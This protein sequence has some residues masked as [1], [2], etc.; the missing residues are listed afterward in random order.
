M[1]EENKKEILTKEMIQQELKTIYLIN[2]KW[3]ITFCVLL[4]IITI[5]SFSVFMPFDNSENF[6]VPLFFLCFFIVRLLYTVF[7]IRKTLSRIQNNCIQ[8]TKDALL[9]CEENLIASLPTKKPHSEFYSYFTKKSPYHLRFQCSGTYT[10]PSGKNYRYCRMYD[11]E[12]KGVY[13]YSNVGDDFYIITMG[14]NEILL[15]YNTKLFELQE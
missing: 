9:E 10:I 14:E 1:K 2:R 6:L 15:A 7:K 5:F 11:M 3:D 8:I 13:N 4:G 12:P